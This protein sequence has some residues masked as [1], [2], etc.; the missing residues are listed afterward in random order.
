MS[1]KAILE[2]F[3]VQVPPLIKQ[4]PF[5]EYEID[6]QRIGN[7][8]EFEYPSR[9]QCSVME[10]FGRDAILDEIIVD[11]SFWS[12]I[13]IKLKNGHSQYINTDGSDYK[14]RYFSRDYRKFSGL[15][16]V[17]IS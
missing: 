10:D 6:Y 14:G 12:S 4:K 1:H 13:M 15:S 3:V 9:E 11:N 16:S 7:V 2:G 8:L 17:K 5:T